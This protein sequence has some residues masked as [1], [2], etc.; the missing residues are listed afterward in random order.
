MNDNVY[1]DTLFKLWNLY[2]NKQMNLLK[3][4]FNLS[5]KFDVVQDLWKNSVKVFTR[6]HHH[7]SAGIIVELG[8]YSEYV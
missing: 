6:S 3:Q 1:T 5:L 2:L 8:S 4:I 7:A